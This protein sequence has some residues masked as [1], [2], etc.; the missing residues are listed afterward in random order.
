VQSTAV[1]TEGKAFYVGNQQLVVHGVTYGP[2]RPH[3]EHGEYGAPETV[4]QDFAA[5]VV[6][7]VNVV[8]LYT[9]P[10]LWFFDVAAEHGLR[11]M[12]GLAWQQHTAFLDDRALVKKILI[13]AREQ[14]RLI[15]RHPALFAIAVGNEIPAKIVRWHGR[16]RIEKF[17]KKL[18]KAVRDEAPEALVSYV[19]YPTTEYLELPF[20]DFVSFNVF[21]E[22]RENLVKYLARLQN[23]AGE[24]PLLL[25]EIGLDSQRNG[26]EQQ[27][28]TLHWQIRTTLE[29]GAG[30]FVFKWTDEWFRGGND[31]EDWDFGI[32]DRQR[33]PKPAFEVVKNAFKAPLLDPDKAPRI[34]VVVCSYNGENTIRDCMRAVTVLDYP[35][36]EVLVINDG[37]V[38]R[39]AEIVSEYPSVR[40]IDTEQGGLSRARNIGMR[41]A[42]GEIVAYIDDD[43]FPEPDW[44]THLAL[45]FTSTDH[46]GVGGPNLPPPD[47]PAIADCVA[48]SPG[49][50]SH[51]LFSD[52]V[53]EHLPGCN[54]AF[55][56][57]AIM[58][59]EGFD[60]QFRIAGDDVDLCWRLQDQGGTLGFSPCAVVWHR[61][62]SKVKQ[63]LRQQF[64]YGRAEGILY[65]KWPARYNRL[66]HMRWA[67]QL[68]GRGHSP[69]PP[70]LQVVD[71]GVWGTR[72]FQAVYSSSPGTLWSLTM[73]P[74]WYLAIAV[75]GLLTLVGLTW[76]PLMW[77]AGSAFVLASLV[78]LIQAV[79]GSMAAT[80]HS[81]RRARGERI[82]LH[83]TTAW[84]HLAQPFVRLR[85]RLKTGMSLWRLRGKRSFELPRTANM[86]LWTEQWVDPTG[87][88]TRFEQRLRDHGALVRRGGNVDSW[89]LH[90]NAG[91]LG[92]SRLLSTVEEHGSGK[93]MFRLRAC[94]VVGCAALVGLPLGFLLV[95]VASWHEAWTATTC[96]A[97][98]ALWLAARVFGECSSSLHSVRTAVKVT[99]EQ[100]NMT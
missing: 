55:R 44:L 30:A 32:V 11:V 92:G 18:A 22:Q 4:A 52:S 81:H 100:E 53:A 77:V 56:R 10:P 96:F 66:G 16:R 82:R 64:N 78:P 14:A 83:I 2:F 17:L 98:L 27:A 25:T 31:I 5:M 29:A 19:S 50:P 61:R 97:I 58:A 70:G 34:S 69:L 35:N 49:G 68:Y 37:S 76:A 26:E 93:Q 72:L 74:E 46:V 48:N 54:M 62:R 60:E 8:R 9:M 84:L 36:Y 57:D 86:Q 13:D 33:H 23:L 28:A 20:L 42:S 41:T 95:F 89:D 65:Q 80:F 38:D 94:P 39:T 85:G 15:G 73:I 45:M 24:K 79:R 59:I 75:L 67:G 6:A 3:P 21:L 91:L 47:D 71:Q 12:V 63:Y 43:A 7:G 88:L 51:V 40:R 87:L 99:C 1:R 90:V